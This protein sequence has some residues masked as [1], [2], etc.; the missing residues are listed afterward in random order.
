MNF[1]SFRTERTRGGI[2]AER[3]HLREPVA[4]TGIYTV[5]AGYD[6]LSKEPVR[7]T[8]FSKKFREHHARA[9]RELMRQA[10]E[11]LARRDPLFRNILFVGEDR[12][13]LVLVEEPIQG[14][15]LLAMLQRRMR[16]S[17][18]L[19]LKEVLAL[20]GL[21]CKALSRVHRFTVHGFVNPEEIDVRPWPGGPVPWRIRVG[22]I[23]LRRA[24]RTEGLAL[25][26][27]SAEGACFVPPEF[28]SHR[29][30][31]PEADVYGLGAIYYSLLTLRLPTGCFEPPSM[32]RAG[33]PEELDRV[34]LQAM[35][36]DPEERIGHVE[37]F[38]RALRGLGLSL[39]GIEGPGGGPEGGVEGAGESPGADLQT[40]VLPADRPALAEKPERPP[41]RVGWLASFWSAPGSWKI[42]SVLLSGGLVALAAGE[43]V[44]RLLHGWPGQGD[45]RRWEGLFRANPGIERLL[46][47]VQAA[48][49]Q[50]GYASASPREGGSP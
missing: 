23:G 4:T 8:V 44:L 12:D 22:W 15:P 1:T 39:G 18:P 26:G 41:A 48:S 13:R 6:V 14:E 27:L 11:N 47:D 49:A 2:L 34:L 21:L 38:V 45:I 17:E 19:D 32:A 10:G 43:F 25:E 16:S 29:P 20:G 37:A 9:A 50:Q 33:I 7:V 30:L 5:F 40:P 36:E 42:L 3:Y 24:L 31:G 35:D 28:S 46:S